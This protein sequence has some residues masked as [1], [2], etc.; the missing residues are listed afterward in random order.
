MSRMKELE[1]SSPSFSRQQDQ[2][3]VDGGD[4]NKGCLQST[5]QR[6]LERSWVL[7]LAVTSLALLRSLR[8]EG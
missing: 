1:I 5:K 2:L 3:K 7:E 6:A 4:S 8:P